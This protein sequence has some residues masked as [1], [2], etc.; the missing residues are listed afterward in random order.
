ME[1]DEGVGGE[2]WRIF[3]LLH[4]ASPEVWVS[5]YSSVW[6][7]TFLQCIQRKE[8]F[9]VQG[10]FNFEKGGGGRGKGKKL[11]KGVT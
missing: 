9:T 10:R 3:Y 11:K 8:V 2:E 4:A 1:G 7:A 6:T 5:R